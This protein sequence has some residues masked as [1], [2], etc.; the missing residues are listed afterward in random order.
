MSM[1][2]DAF[3]FRHLSDSEHVVQFECGDRDLNDFIMTDAPLY[4]QKLLA[5]NYVLEA[6]DCI[7]AYF[8]LLNDRIGIENFDDNTSFNKFRRKL[9]VNSKRLRGY[10]AVKIG[11]LAVRKCDSGKGY[12]SVI[13]DFIKMLLVSMRTSACRFITVDAY[14]E[15]IPFYEKNGFAK[16]S[17]GESRSHTSLMYFDLMT[18]KQTA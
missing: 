4:Q 2:K 10:P 3:A 14:K 1:G 18:L 7:L 6:K 12:G 11:R 15:A 8:S 5:E 13:L 16:L 9:F 17:D